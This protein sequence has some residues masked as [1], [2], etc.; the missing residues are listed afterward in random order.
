MCILVMTYATYICVVDG[1]HVQLDHT[2]EERTIAKVLVNYLG[3][4]VEFAPQVLMPQNVRTSDYIVDST[5]YELKTSTGA[6]KNTAFDMIKH[7]K[8][9]ASH[10]VINIDRT[11]LSK[12]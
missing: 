2:E 7:R 8:G 12:N 4:N 10:F 9:Q 1:K 11:K 5:P 3:K 6:G